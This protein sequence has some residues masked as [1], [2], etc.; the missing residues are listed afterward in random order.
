MDAKN[1]KKQNQSSYFLQVFSELLLVRFY[2]FD[3]HAAPAVIAANLHELARQDIHIKTHADERGFYDF[4]VLKKND[5]DINIHASGRIIIHGGTGETILRGHV[6]MGFFAALLPLFY[7]ILLMSNLISGPAAWGFFLFILLTHVFT[8]LHTYED[9]QR[10]IDRIGD[11]I[12]ASESE[13]SMPPK[14]EPDVYYGDDLE[15]MLISR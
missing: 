3:T 12:A 2:E 11:V 6:R 13:L 1:K 7:A 14:S 5:S 10:M 15:D 9:R 4:Y 8:W